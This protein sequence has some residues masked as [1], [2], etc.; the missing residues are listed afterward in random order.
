MASIL[1]PT[2]EFKFLSYHDHSSVKRIKAKGIEGETMFT[3]RF[4]LANTKT[5]YFR[6]NKNLWEVLAVIGGFSIAAIFAGK[7]A[8]AIAKSNSSYILT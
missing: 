4:E 5:V 6:Q 1:I 2:S 7:V 8:Y 3:T